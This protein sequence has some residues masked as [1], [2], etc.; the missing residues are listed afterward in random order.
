MI[1]AVKPAGEGILFVFWF[2]HKAR[3][4][5]GEQR[6]GG[7]GLLQEG[8]MDA[9]RRL[10]WVFLAAALL[11]GCQIAQEK[12]ATP[13]TIVSLG[14]SMTMGIQDAGLV[15]ENQYNCYPYLLAK[16]MGQARGF[17]QPLVNEPG[18]GVPPYERPLWL[19]DGMIEAQYLD[20][21]ITQ[22]ELVMLIM[23]RLGNLFWPDP[24]NNLGVN[25]ARLDDLNHATGYATSSSGENLFYDI[26]LRNLD[27]PLPD[28]GDTTA[29]EQAIM[30]EP[31]YITLWIG[32]N[33]IL[34]YVLGGGEQS[35]LITDT[36]T[37]RTELEATITKLQAEVPDA[38][39]VVANIPQY[40]PFGYAL[41][42]VFGADGK[43]KIFDPATLEPIDFDPDAGEELYIDLH[44][45]PEDG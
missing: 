30:L 20:P 3:T 1:P 2:F 33:D 43:P 45:G 32:N 21:G 18:I 6:A 17:Q 12:P 36:T 35:G 8:N 25:G 37:F 10:L 44:V 19:E 27:A 15:A 28:F 4:T 9:T 7:L 31:E 40:L 14:D 22:Q 42:S 24:Y 13:S 5:T 39:I 38:K 34:G 26:V 29:V 41:D 11:A 23:S 16:Q